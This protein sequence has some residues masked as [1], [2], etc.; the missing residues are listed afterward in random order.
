[1]AKVMVGR[2][3]NGITLNPLEF[4]LNDDGDVMMFDTVQEAKDFLTSHEVAENEM[5]YLYFVDE[6]GNHYDMD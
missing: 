3:M 2:H 4:V 5:K 1:M 6:E